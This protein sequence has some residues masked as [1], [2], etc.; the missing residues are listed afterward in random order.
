M[1]AGSRCGRWPRRCRTSKAWHSCGVEGSRRHCGGDG[2]MALAGVEGTAGG[3]AG[4]LLPGGAWPSSSGSMGASPR[5]PKVNSASRISGAFSP[6]Q[7]WILRHMRRYGPPCLRAFHS[8]SPS[9][10]IHVLP[11]NRS[12]GPSEPRQG[13]RIR[14]LCCRDGVPKSGTDRSGR[15]TAASFQRTRSFA[16]AQCRTAP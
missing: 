11:T 1:S 10:L 2:T 16:G 12:G 4:D 7:I 14:V 3:E 9:I 5:S 8:P 13:I 6:N 15:S